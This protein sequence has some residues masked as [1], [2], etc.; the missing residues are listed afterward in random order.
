MNWIRKIINLCKRWIT[1]LLSKEDNMHET[2]DAENDSRDNGNKPTTPAIEP[3][4]SHDR[5]NSNQTAGD[6]GITATPTR[7][8]ISPPDNTQH[9]PPLDPVQ[10]PQ[11][12]IHN[13]KTD[14]NRGPIKAPGK[15][16]Q[17]H[18]KHNKNKSDNS[19]IKPKP[20]FICRN[21]S[22]GW[23]IFL[24]VNESRE[25][26]EITQNGS[27]L[28]TL[29]NEYQL[30]S[31]TENLLTIFTD[32]SSDKIT[33]Y[34]ENKPLIFK[35]KND[36]SDDGREISTLT[37]GHFIVIAPQQWERIGSNIRVEP[38]FCS[39]KRFMA[40]FYFLDKDAS[41]QNYEFRDDE[42][43]PIAL[44]SSIAVEL[45]GKCLFTNNE[46]EL[47]V[48]NLPQI[49]AGKNIVWAR[50]GEEKADGWGENIKLPEQKLIDVMAQRQGRFFLRVYDENIKMQDSISF[51][52]I[53]GLEKITINGGEY[54]ENTILLPDKSGHTSTRIQF[55]GNNID[56]TAKNTCK[57]MTK[58]EN[59]FEVA[60]YAA[61]DKQ[62]F[63]CNSNNDE[64][65]ISLHLP[66]IWWCMNNESADWQDTCF[67]M[68]PEKFKNYGDANAEIHLW[69][70]RHIKRVE[71]AWDNQQGRR[72]PRQNQNE[73]GYSLIPIPLREFRYDNL[74]DCKYLKAIIGD[75]VQQ[76]I[77][78]AQPEIQILLPKIAH[79]AS[80]VIPM[81]KRSWGYR[82]GKGFSAGEV[83]QALKGEMMQKELKYLPVDKRRKSIHFVNVDKIVRIA[84]EQQ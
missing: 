49:I 66:R 7:E 56:L 35:M 25:I 39:D 13:E 22:T 15:R 34:K 53:Q 11:N 18:Q 63:T 48:G 9:Q 14:S 38:E 28:N 84:N 29:N 37:K 60:P 71:I 44:T 82:H 45:K 55:I 43:K 50:V 21:L 75:K 72:Y 26:R 65:T 51:R 83:T 8:I 20:E 78:I 58:N 70:P 77:Q 68:T 33:L 24:S 57:L 17:K 5:I 59:A 10:L 64:V 4:I 16:T 30:T 52:Y 47:F 62:I 42:G 6:G 12:P 76:L 61:Y 32:G 46:N 40:H 41:T 67:Q 19:F 81:V 3:E 23:S 31:F 79:P 54:V 36:W 27:C 73:T 69:L 1:Q 80:S 74:D 2:S